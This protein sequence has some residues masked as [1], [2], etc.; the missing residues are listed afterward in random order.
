[1]PAVALAWQLTRPAHTA[2]IVGAN[3]PEQLAELLPGAD[4]MLS[5]ENVRELD[6]VSAGL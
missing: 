6:Q 1:V 2:P 5:G 4:L 3:T